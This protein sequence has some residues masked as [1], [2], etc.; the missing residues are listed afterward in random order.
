MK[1]RAPG[2]AAAGSVVG[3]LA[4]RGRFWTVEPFFDRG[5]RMNVDRPRDAGPGRAGRGARQAGPVAGAARRGARRAR[6]ADARPR[7]AAAVRPARRARG[8]RRRRL[9]EVGAAATCAPCPP[10]RSIRR[11]RATSTTRSPPSGST[12]ARCASGCTSPTSRPTC[13]R[14]RTSTARRSGAPPR[15]TCQGWSSRCC[16]RRS[17]TRRARWC[18]TRT[19][20]PSPWRWTSRA[21]RVRRSAFHRSIIRS[22]QRLTYPEVDEL[23]AGAARRG[24]AGRRRGRRPPRW[25]T[26]APRRARGRELGAGVRLL[27]RGPRDAPGGERADRVAPP[28]RAPDD[29]RQRGGGHAAR[30]AQAAGALPRARAAG[31]GAAWSGWSSSSRRW[32]SRRRRS[33]R[34]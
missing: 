22:D 16:P 18:P 31:A 26:R 34:R 21:P 28:D 9:P 23:F 17:P 30:D 2:R 24:A 25:P 3:V 33:R 27:A 32:T 7:A 15:S 29:R 8:A 12:A 10:S 13:G 4:K 14:A 19:G 6:G 11:P 1:Q 5:P 20:W